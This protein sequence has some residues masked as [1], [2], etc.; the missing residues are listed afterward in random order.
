MYGLTLYVCEIYRLLVG[1]VRF[2]GCGPKGVTK[3]SE[4]F[5]VASTKKN[6]SI[7]SRFAVRATLGAKR[8]P[9]PPVQRN[10]FAPRGPLSFRR[11]PWPLLIPSAAV[12][13]ATNPS[14]G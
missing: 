6:F 8:L 12:R 10:S 14:G 7:A 1:T 4:T 2:E 11:P 9:W 3:V 5:A 13:Q